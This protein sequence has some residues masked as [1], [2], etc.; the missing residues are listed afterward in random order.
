MEILACNQLQNETNTTGL[1]IGF[2]KRWLYSYSLVQ[3]EIKSVSSTDFFRIT[4]HTER[5]WYTCSYT[6]SPRRCRN[7]QFVI[8][9][10][11]FARERFFSYLYVYAKSV[12]SRPIASAPACKWGDKRAGGRIAYSRNIE[13]LLPLSIVS[14]R[15]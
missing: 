11:V 14:N 1:V 9:T 5:R 15:R 4:K 8:L 13:I 6:P 10:R 3:Y 12:H 2:S 7:K